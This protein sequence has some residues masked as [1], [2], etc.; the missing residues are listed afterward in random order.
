MK[1]AFVKQE[2][3]ESCSWSSFRYNE[4]SP[5]KIFDV[6]PG[7]ASLWEMTCLLEADWYVVPQMVETDYTR[8]ILNRNPE[9]PQVF[10]KYVKN[11]VKPEDIPFEEYDVVIT[12]DPIFHEMTDC[13]SLLTYYMVEHW[14][15]FY[16]SS[17]DKPLGHYDLFL[18]HMMDA[19]ESLD[20]LPQAINMPYLRAPETMREIFNEPKQDK[21][22]AEWRALTALSMKHLWDG[23]CVEAAKR[24]EKTLGLPVAYKGDFFKQS[25][26]FKDEP[27]WGDAKNYL[28]EIGRCKYY[29]AIGRDNG[30]GQGLADAVSL[31]C[32]C[33]GEANKAYH[34]MLCHPRCICWNMVE[35]PRRIKRIISD[36]SL[37]QEILEWQDRMLG[38]R[39]IKQPIENLERA[40]EMKKEA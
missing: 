18:A 28:A 12:F 35:L 9:W 32:I 1:V 21:I 39:F 36:V 2:M 11:L 15:Q 10:R 31:G 14:D 29:L 22:W 17:L 6:W 20:K 8:D 26:G 19:V 5:M 38:E 37:Q 4:T 27:S 16:R 24:L 3:H 33:I 30:P 23:S 13:P 7:K 34:L 25:Y 40:I